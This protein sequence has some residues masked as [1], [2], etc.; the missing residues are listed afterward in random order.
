MRIIGVFDLSS[1]HPNPFTIE[2]GVEVTAEID[3]QQFL[4]TDVI[5]CYGE[6]NEASVLNPN[7]NFVYSW[8][9]ENSNDLIDIGPSTS[10]LPAG[11]IVVAASYELGLWK[12]LQVL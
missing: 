11:N 1:L 12:L 9:L 7:P 6:S 2:N 3:P 8:Y 10:S 4:L 5:D